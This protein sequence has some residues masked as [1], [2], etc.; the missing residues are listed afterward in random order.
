MSSCE[1]QKA[2]V[3]V[4][5]SPLCFKLSMVAPLRHLQQPCNHEN[6]SIRILF[7]VSQEV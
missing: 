3:S 5:W 2:W 6:G 1:K 7:D 4:M